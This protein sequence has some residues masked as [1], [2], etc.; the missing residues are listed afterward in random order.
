MKL[1]PVKTVTDATRTTIQEA[2]NGLRS[3]TRLD[4]RKPQRA[5]SVAT[6]RTV[7]LR[8]RADC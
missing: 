3:L 1:L 4:L 8:V 2:R 6:L 5:R 7:Q